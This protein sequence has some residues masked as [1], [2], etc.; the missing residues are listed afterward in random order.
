MSKVTLDPN[1]KYLEGT[2]RVFDPETTRANT[3]KLLPKIGVTRI[4]N[5]TDL[6]RERKGERIKKRKKRVAR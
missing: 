3:T 1:I 4:A 5:I 2:Q 6:D